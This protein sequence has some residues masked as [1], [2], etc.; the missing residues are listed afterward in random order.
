MRSTIRGGRDRAPALEYLLKALDNIPEG[1]GCME[2]PWART[3]GGYGNIRIK[4]KNVCVSRWV[5]ERFNSPLDPSIDVCHSC[6]NPACFRPSHLFSGTRVQNMADC[7]SKGRAVHRGA[8]GERNRN[9]V[10]DAADVLEIK[11][12]VS[13]GTVRADLCI[14]YSVTISCINHI[15]AGHTW[16]HLR[17]SLPQ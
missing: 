12:L 9:A 5:W 10:L 6:D 14:R 8:V 17:G 2:W 11:R 1:D 16:K 3:S 13:R 4:G 15:I 7:E